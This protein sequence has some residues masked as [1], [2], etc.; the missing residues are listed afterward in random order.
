MS[1]CVVAVTADDTNESL[2][3]T[4]NGLAAKTI[5]WTATVDTTETGFTL[6]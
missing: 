5:R 2:A 3:I 6:R 4:V 1:G